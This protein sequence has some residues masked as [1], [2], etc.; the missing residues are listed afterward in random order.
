MRKE[1]TISEKAIVTEKMDRYIQI[2]C[3]DLPKDHHNRIV[4]VPRFP[5][6]Y[7]IGTKGKVIYRSDPNCGLLYFLGSTK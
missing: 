3:K 4:N 2:T 6:D 5:K 7:A 1:K